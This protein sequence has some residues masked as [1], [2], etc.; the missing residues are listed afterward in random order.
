MRIS[1]RSH[2]V[3][4]KYLTT[5]GFAPPSSTSAVDLPEI[6]PILDSLISNSNDDYLYLLVSTFLDVLRSFYP[7]DDAQ[8]TLNN[9]ISERYPKVSSESRSCILG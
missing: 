2:P 8:V 4:F 3:A 9:F 6:G 5:K 1:P 7:H